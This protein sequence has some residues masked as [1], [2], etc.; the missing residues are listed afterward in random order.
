M[1]VHLQLLV[2]GENEGYPQKSAEVTPLLAALK[3]SQDPSK[4]WLTENAIQVI[5]LGS[6]HSHPRKSQLIPWN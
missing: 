2:L 3:A 5:K 1:G 6:C 4:V